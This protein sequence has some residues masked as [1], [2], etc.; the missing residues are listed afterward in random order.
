MALNLGVGTPIVDL[1]KGSRGFNKSI[2]GSIL[3]CELCYE[4]PSGLRI[5]RFENVKY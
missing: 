1:R 4:S 2:E 5:I 3:C